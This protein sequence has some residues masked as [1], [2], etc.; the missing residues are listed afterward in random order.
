MLAARA[1]V[2][3]RQPVPAYRAARAGVSCRRIDIL[4]AAHAGGKICLHRV[5]LSCLLC[6]R[7][8]ISAIS[9][10]V[11]LA[12]SP[13]YPPVSLLGVSPSSAY[14]SLSPH[15]RIHSLCLPHRRIS[16]YLFSSARPVSHI[17]RHSLCFSHLPR[18]CGRCH[19]AAATRTGGVAEMQQ[20]L[21]V[22]DSDRRG[23]GGTEGRVALLRLSVPCG[24]G[25]GWEVVSLPMGASAKAPMG[26]L[27]SGALPSGA[28]P[29]GASA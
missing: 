16:R 12:A 26:A 6:V 23:G 24:A 5:M 29:S 18:R 13:G 25:G 21:Q 22:S 4:L 28:L 27:P 7:R 17:S 19:V 15:R 11:C 20:R 2:S 9:V 1:G 14:L 8:C 10:P 3:C